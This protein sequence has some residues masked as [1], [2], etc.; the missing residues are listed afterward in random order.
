[1]SEYAPDAIKQLFDDVQAGIPS[2][3]MGGIQ[4]DAAHT[5]GY[6]RGR[7]YCTSSGDYSTQLAEDKQ[8]DGQACS[9]LDISWNRAEDQ[10][11]ASRRLLDAKH[12][13]RMRAARSFFGSTDGVTVCGWD[14]AGDYPTSSD[15]SHLWHVHLSILRK[16]ATDYAALAPIADV[17]TG[18]GGKDQDMPAHVSVDR[19][20]PANLKAGKE[21]DITWDVENEDKGGVFGGTKADPKARLNLDG[22]YYVSTFTAAVEGLP[23][24]RSMHTSVMFCDTQGNDTGR[25]SLLEH[26]AGSDTYLNIADVRSYKAGSDRAVKI[27]VKAPVDVVLSGCQWRV[28]YWKIG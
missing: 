10:Y 21:V 18:T 28:H 5:Y 20:T 17:I 8:G 6:H 13:D 22:A 3:L 14:Y 15:D 16:Y 11:A 24:G 7:D 26:V 4:G 1:M 9:A 19:S 12:D 27:R 23:E 25:S 2:A